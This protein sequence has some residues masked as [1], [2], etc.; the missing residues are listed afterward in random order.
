VDIN[1]LDMA[2]GNRVSQT[3]EGRS[4]QD[5]TAV[6]FIDIALML[7]AVRFHTFFGDGQAKGGLAIC[8]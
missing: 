3:L 6:A 5:R 7:A 4:R 1:A 2:T 8:H